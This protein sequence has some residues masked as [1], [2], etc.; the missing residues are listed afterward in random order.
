MNRIWLHVDAS[1]NHAI[2]RLE[3]AGFS[4]EATLCQDRYSDGGYLD[5]V[6]MGMLRGSVGSAE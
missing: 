5:T 6:V 3:K 4:H 2:Q 1:D